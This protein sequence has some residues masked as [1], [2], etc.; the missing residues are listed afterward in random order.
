[1]DR[2]CIERSREHLVVPLNYLFIGDDFFGANSYLIT[3]G[4]KPSAN[5]D[6]NLSLLVLQALRDSFK[7]C[8]NLSQ[9]SFQT[10]GKLVLTD[11]ITQLNL[12]INEGNRCLLLSDQLLLKLVHVQ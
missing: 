8:I 9:F 11:L 2:D 6:L 12:L 3:E 7:N 5:L 1:M 4:V 10:L